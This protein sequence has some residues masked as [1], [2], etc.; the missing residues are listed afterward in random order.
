MQ[1][2]PGLA[3]GGPL[4]TCRK[5]H[6][7]QVLPRHN[8][9]RDLLPDT[10]KQESWQLLGACPLLWYVVCTDCKVQV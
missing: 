2:A 6:V 4:W 10:S 8:L 1:V 9:R 7:Q 3:Q 5:L